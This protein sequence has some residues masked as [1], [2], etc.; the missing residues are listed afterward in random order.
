MSKEDYI[1]AVLRNPVEGLLDP[2]PIRAMCDATKFQDGLVWHCE[3]VNGGVGN[4][5]NMW[6][7]CLRYAIEAGGMY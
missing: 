6:L 3:L 7:N 5:G 4:V 2:A 1:A